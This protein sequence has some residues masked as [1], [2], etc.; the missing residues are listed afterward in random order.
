[1]IRTQVQLTEEQMRRL[2]DLAAKR[3]VSM[4]EIIRQAVDVMVRSGG[5]IPPEERRRRALQAVGRFA[6]GHRDTGEEHDKYL[7]EAYGSQREHV[8]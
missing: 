3:G 4:A 1:M 7:D 6:S 2:R 5:D 8:R